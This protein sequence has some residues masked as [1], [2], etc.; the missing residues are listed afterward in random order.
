M[1]RERKEEKAKEEGRKRF[2]SEESPERLLGYFPLAR[3]LN[4]LDVRDHFGH[5]QS[6]KDF[7]FPLYD[8]FAALVFARAVDPCSKLRTFH[9][10]IPSLYMDC[11]CSYDQILSAVEFIGSEYEK[12]TEILTAATKEN[13][14]MDTSTSYFDCTNFYFEIDRENDFQRRGP[15]KEHRADPIVGLGLL[16]DADMIPV[17]MRMYPGNE[18]EKPVL[19]NIISD[20]KKRNNITGRT[21]QIA[22]K[23]LNC[24][25]NIAEAKKNG[26]GYLF[27]KSVRQLPDKEKKWVLLSDGYTDV[28]DS[29]GSIIYSYKSCIDDY[30]YTYNDDSGERV[31]VTLREKRVVT[32]SP[33]LAAKKMAEIKKMADKA[34]KMNAYN[35]KRSEYGESARYIS[36][37]DGEGNKARA[38]INEDAIERDRQLAGYNMLI[39]SETGMDSMKIYEAYHHLWRIEES[40][41]VM[42]SQLDARPVYLQKEDSIKGHFF[43]CYAAVLL[44]R[45]LQFRELEG[46]FSTEEIMRFIKEFR[47]VKIS[48]NKYINL[49]RRSDFIDSLTDMLNLPLTNYYLTEKQ[50]KM[51]H[52]R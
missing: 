46:K 23:G 8:V 4:N 34:R 24:A 38:V 2:I 31:S 17:G 12:F 14:G 29:N 6:M 49:T 15:S 25:R 42:K 13:Y 43:I 21:V 35:A 19:R 30:T 52:D 20:L 40:F 7:R 36:F 32:Y 22:D 37:T 39:T 51:M 28:R 9:D 16:L 26:D 5:M 48:S 1:N 11:G 41:R 10:V 50:I 33:K 44:L 27:S 3:V 47:V 45:L 18:S